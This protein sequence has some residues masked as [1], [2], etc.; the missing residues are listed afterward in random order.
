MSE[1]KVLL[2][3][4]KYFTGRGFDGGDPASLT[5]CTLTD[6][7]PDI[8]DKNIPDYLRGHNNFGKIG[9]WSDSNRMMRVS[10]GNYF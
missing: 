1:P 5:L 6:L 7:C 9:Q 4:L 8:A 2:E 3:A 10:L